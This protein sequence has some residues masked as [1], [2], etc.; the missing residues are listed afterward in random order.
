[1]RHGAK[2]F[3]TAVAA[4][5]TLVGCGAG[6]GAVAP[7]D[8]AGIV[9]E[10]RSPLLATCVPE[11][12]VVPPGGSLRVRAFAGPG[13]AGALRYRWRAEH[14]RLTAKGDV[15]Q[16]SL[17]GLEPG[18]YR[19]EAAVA[20]APDATAACA[21][22]VVVAE[23][24]M[25]LRPDSAR[26]LLRRQDQEAAGYL[27]YSYLLLRTALDE[28][29]AATRE[30]YLRTI[31]AYRKIIDGLAAQQVGYLRRE[32]NVTYLPVVGDI[33]AEW[34]ADWAHDHYDYDRAKFLLANPALQRNFHDGPYIVSCMGPLSSRETG[35]APCVINDLSLVELHLI[36]PWVSAYL[37]QMAQE[38][39]WTDKSLEQMG[40]ETR[41]VLAILARGTYEVLPA[42]KEWISWVSSTTATA[43]ESAP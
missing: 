35:A 29:S 23:P 27:R 4:V 5:L 14:G 25:S 6:V 24:V 39:G 43:N 16:W 8:A 28:Q 21:A 19:I 30:R 36:D 22:E 1:M 18:R 38:H 9:S 41:N 12:P 13:D 3:A 33:P 34:T 31:Q 7:G 17:A 11:S 40:L 2:V 26:M 37:N 20:R 15:A 32:L 42:I 10:P